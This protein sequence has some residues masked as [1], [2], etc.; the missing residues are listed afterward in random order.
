MSCTQARQIPWWEES[1]MATTTAVAPEAPERHI[2]AFGRI[3]GALV[4]PR[5]T[6]EDIA[7]KPSWLVPIL[8]MTVISIVLSV[9]INQRVDWPQVVQQRIEKSHFASQRLDQL[10]PE[11]RQANLELQA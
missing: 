9:A 3:I 6:F 2:G 8:V 10:P 11:Q 4:N 7:R 1:I 5:P